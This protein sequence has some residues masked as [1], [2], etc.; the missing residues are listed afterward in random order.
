M[1]E[2]QQKLSENLEDYLETISSL[3]AG[4]G[5]ARPSDIAAAMSVKRQSVTA[6]LNSLREKGLVEYE[7]YKPVTLTKDGE[8]VAMNVRRKHRLLSDFFTGVLGVN[9]SEADLAA[10]RMEHALEDSIMRKL[11]KFLKGR[12]TGMCSACPNRSP[13]CEATCPHAMPLSELSKG[14]RALVLSIDKKIGN[15]ATYAGMGLTIGSTVS[16]L[17]VAPLGDP[18]IISVHGSEISMRKS[19]LRNIMVKRI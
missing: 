15:L 4:T 16:I 10:C 11:V 17:R 13:T 19:Q 18:V 2:N 14:E 3:S 9:A 8:A 7:K 6:A 12:G 5:A 1:P